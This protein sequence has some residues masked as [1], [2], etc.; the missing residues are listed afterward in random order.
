MNEKIN[1]KTFLV[2]FTLT[3]VHDLQFKA[4]YKRLLKSYLSVFSSFFFFLDNSLC[5]FSSW[6]QGIRSTCDEE[7]DSVFGLHEGACLPL[8]SGREPG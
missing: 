4:V 8:R 7:D 6:F 1:V 5:A 3:I 2:K